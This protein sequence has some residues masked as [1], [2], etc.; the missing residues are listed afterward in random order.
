MSRV[1][2][3]DGRYGLKSPNRCWHYKQS[4]NKVIVFFLFV[5]VIGNDRD[6]LCRKQL[7][8]LR[9]GSILAQLTP[10]SLRGGYQPYFNS[11]I[12]FTAVLPFASRR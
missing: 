10:R 4:I 11:N 6:D 9:L 8:V 2:G 12:F 3:K 1:P 5:R 7:L